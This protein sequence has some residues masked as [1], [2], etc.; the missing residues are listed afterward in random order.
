LPVLPHSTREVFLRVNTRSV[1][2]ILR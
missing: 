1:N 2:K